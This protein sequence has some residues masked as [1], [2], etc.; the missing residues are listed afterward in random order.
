MVH[1][2]TIDKFGNLLKFR[3]KAFYHPDLPGRLFSPQAYLR[4]Q[5]IV[6]NKSFN[7]D[8]H[9]R[10]YHDRAEWHIDGQLLLTLDFDSC[11]LPTMTMFQ[12][13]TAMATL[14]A[15]TAV[16]KETNKNLSPFRNS[17]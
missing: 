1:W 3:H 15:M 9:F 14:K 6:H 2:E 12:E 4:E 8:D 10:V 17:G 5:S 13:G 16:V 11:F 7:L